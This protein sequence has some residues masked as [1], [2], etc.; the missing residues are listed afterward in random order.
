MD[1]DQ[2]RDF[3]EEAANQHLMHEEC[4]GCDTCEPDNYIGL[5]RGDIEDDYEQALI[6]H[7][8]GLNAPYTDK[9]GRRTE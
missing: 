2:E 7:I 3:L 6:E 4:I 9:I 5:H 1:N 8:L